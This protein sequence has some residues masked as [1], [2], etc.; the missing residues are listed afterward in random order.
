MK[1]VH[2]LLLLFSAVVLSCTP[3][4]I[5]NMQDSGMDE[6]SNNENGEGISGDKDSGEDLSY[7]RCCEVVSKNDAGVTTKVV[8]SYDGKK[9]VGEKQ[10]MNDVLWYSATREFSGLSYSGVVKQYD[11]TT[12]D[13]ISTAH[14]QGKYLDETYLRC[15][16]AVV[17]YDTGVTTKVVFL[18]DGKKLVGEKQYMNGVLWY[19]ATREFSGLSYSEVAK[20]YNS[21]TGELMNVTYRNGVYMN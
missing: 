4:E 5:S 18:Y 9:L 21:T 8:F 17:K 16:E 19:S 11:S 14:C 3:N 2:I 7:L 10:Y 13:L 6:M 12:G 15:C 20:Q 1:F